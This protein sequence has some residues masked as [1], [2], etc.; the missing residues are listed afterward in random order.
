MSDKKYLLFT[1]DIN[2]ERVT[3]EVR[4]SERFD[5]DV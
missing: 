5:W 1:P 3:S 2:Y 4:T